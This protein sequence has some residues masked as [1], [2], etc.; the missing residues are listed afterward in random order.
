MRTPRLIPAWAGK[1]YC[2]SCPSSAAAAHPRVGGENELLS[3]G[4]DP[5]AGSSPRGRGKLARA[6]ARDA[7]RRLIPAWAGKT[8]RTCRREARRGAHPR[9]GG[10]NPSFSAML[11]AVFG[12][13]PRGRGKRPAPARRGQDH[14]LIPAWAGK[15]SGNSRRQGCRRAHPRVGGENDV[16]ACSRSARAGSSPRGRGKP[17]KDQDNGT[18]QRLIPAWA[19]KT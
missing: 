2:R 15:T 11:S 16:S 3:L 7:R 1:T 14:R 9:V 17:R 6:S 13:S 12:S 10:E 19:G 8:T 18:E 5:V 4:H